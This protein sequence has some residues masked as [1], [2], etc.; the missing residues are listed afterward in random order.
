M[1]RMH[2]LKKKEPVG[3]LFSEGMY[4]W[5]LFITNLFLRVRTKLQIDYESFM[6]L[7]IVAGNYIYDWNRYGSKSFDKISS[8]IEKVVSDKLE[9]NRITVSSIASILKIPRETVKRKMLVL[10]EKKLLFEKKD[11]SIS[12]GEGYRDYF[13]NFVFETTQDVSKLVTK[14]KTKG[15]LDKLI[16]FNE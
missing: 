8:S 6:I 10:V 9:I 13:E 4:D 7:H 12:I 14:W 11:K 15:I 1:V 3:D 2:L 5:S 16:E